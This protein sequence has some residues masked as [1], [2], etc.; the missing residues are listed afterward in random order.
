MTSLLALYSYSGRIGLL[1]T[2]IG[3]GIFFLPQTEKP[4]I[5]HSGNVQL[6]TPQSIPEMQNLWLKYW[7]LRGGA[8]GWGTV[9]QVGS[10][11]VRFPMMSL[12]FFIDIILPALR[13]TQP[14][15]EMSTRNISWEVKAVGAYG[16]QP[17]HLHVPIVF[18]SGSLNLLEPSGP[19]QACNGIALPF[20]CT[21]FTWLKYINKIK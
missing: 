21:F 16:W 1:G 4:P 3:R 19:V 9:L 12:E 14:L 2:K 6:M 20:F 11:R 10:S 7:G 8:F 18:K 13:L 5:C 17:Y 15:T